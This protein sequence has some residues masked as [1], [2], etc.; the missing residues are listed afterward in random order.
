MWCFVAHHS[1]VIVADVPKANIV[2]PD[3]QNIRLLIRASV[4]R[5]HQD[6]TRDCHRNKKQMSNWMHGFQFFSWMKKTKLSYESTAQC[7]DLFLLRS[8]FKADLL[9]PF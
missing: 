5:M 4:A 1:T 3:N 6:N 9:S 2:T 8:V 7:N